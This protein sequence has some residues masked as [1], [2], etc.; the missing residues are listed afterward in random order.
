MFASGENRQTRCS[1]D[2][3]AGTRKEKSTPCR[4][5]ETGPQFVLEPRDIRQSPAALSSHVSHSC[6]ASSACK[7]RMLRAVQPCVTAHA[8]TQLDPVTLV[9]SAADL[10]SAVRPVHA[11]LPVPAAPPRAQ[12]HFLCRKRFLNLSMTR[13]SDESSVFLPAFMP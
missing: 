10:S 8:A 2:S 5:T 1:D 4:E 12:L 7:E 11:P 3:A 13:S 6:C 9:H